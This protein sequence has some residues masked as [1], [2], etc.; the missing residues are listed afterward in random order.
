MRVLVF[1][2]G[3]V[4]AMMGCGTANK[5][6]QTIQEDTLEVQQTTN[7][8]T[9]PY[10][11]GDSINP[12]GAVSVGK[13][14][15]RLVEEGQIAEIK[16]RGEVAGVCKKKGC[17]MVITD[18]LDS[19]R[20]VFKDYGFF[21]PKDIEGYVV[22]VA[23]AAYYDTFSVAEQRHLA[24][25]AGKSE[26]ELSAI[27]EDIITPMFEARGVVIYDYPSRREE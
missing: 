9:T 19:V 4:I 26:E 1:V 11:I 20:V 7:T 13:L 22:A 3:V 16:V 23:G 12:E 5:D 25:D 10:L 8:E 6:A 14:L 24:E 27:T 21:V 15:N 2:G 18:G 17:W